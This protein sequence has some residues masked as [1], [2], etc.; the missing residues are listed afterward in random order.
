MIKRLF[1]LPIF[2]GTLLLSLML[3]AV[4]NAQG[5]GIT[6]TG[7]SGYITGEDGSY[8][9]TTSRQTGCVHFSIASDYAFA[10]MQFSFS[11]ATRE[12]LVSG[13]DGPAHFPS[14]GWFWAPATYTS[15]WNWYPGD[16][17][18]CFLPDK[19]STNLDIDIIGSGSANIPDYP[20]NLTRLEI[21]N[22]DMVEYDYVA[23]DFSQTGIW[24][25][26][27]LDSLGR[28]IFYNPITTTEMSFYFAP[29]R[30]TTYSSDLGQADFL[31]NTILHLPANTSIITATG[32]FGPGF[33]EFSLLSG[34]NTFFYD[35]RIYSGIPYQPT[36]GIQ[37]PT[38][39]NADFTTTDAWQFGVTGTPIS[40]TASISNSIL[41]FDGAGINVSQPI[42]A[43]TST[44]YTVV[45]SGTGTSETTAELLIT[46]AGYTDT[47][48]LL[49]TD[50]ITN[51]TTAYL[52]PIATGISLPATTTLQLEML[53]GAAAID[54]V[55]FYSGGVITGTCIPIIPNPQFTTDSDWIY[56]NGGVWNNVAQNAFLP[57][58]EG[59]LNGKTVSLV[60]Q[61]ALSGTVPS[62]ADGQYLILRFD[63]RTL[64]GFGAISSVYQNNDI[65]NTAIMT[66]TAP[67]LDR[68]MRYETPFD[69]FAGDQSDV[70]IAFLNNAIEFK[71]QIDPLSGV[72]VDNLCL[73]A[74]TTEAQLP[75]A[76]T[77]PPIAPTDP[78][79]P[80]NP[81]DPTNPGDPN[82]PPPG[83][84][85][86]LSCSDVTK[87]LSS[88]I[89]VDLLALEGMST[90]AI[91]DFSSWVPWLSGRLWVNVGKPISCSLFITGP[92]RILTNYINWATAT[93]RSFTAAMGRTWETL[94]S[95]LGHLVELL[96]R[97][98]TL[99]AV[100][101]LLAVNYALGRW[102]ALWESISTV[103]SLLLTVLMT[104]WNTYI[105]PFFGDIWS[106][107]LMSMAAIGQVPVIG[108]LLVFLFKAGFVVG[109]SI[110]VFIKGIISIPILFY[111]SF[112]GAIN[113]SA[114]ELIPACTADL[115]NP[116]CRVLWGFEVVNHTIS[117]TFLYP[118]IIIGIIVATIGIFWRQ[119]WNVFSIHFR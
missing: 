17:K 10:S 118:I 51:I 36:T 70:E 3:P 54:Y 18:I 90:P 2:L 46:L 103:V 110:W 6:F 69:F 92:G 4:A 42:T 63:A 107:V 55:C 24:G 11:N 81:I 72:Y 102:Q 27:G 105:S 73:Y 74:S 100:A 104:F 7:I 53:S 49:P 16:Y 21:T 9:L 99:F 91:W 34:V 85:Y 86:P 37:C 87:W 83:V 113:Q 112:N 77:D 84:G 65:V 39:T 64:N 111:Q 93:I 66:Y 94:G 44:S 67:V 97:G 119:I 79:N 80:G 31:N 71:D 1:F 48:I 20:T 78:T 45:V 56:D 14:M 23:D 68:W 15:D 59:T 38:L 5:P 96:K 33:Y 57:V 40:A 47:L 76:P 43:T 8:N 95:W 62:V 117:H 52:S 12:I 89:G 106:F 26:L 13:T 82:D 50:P 98:P 88:L 32:I 109:F 58:V 29:N 75:Y 30:N 35:V 61:L 101:V 22:S 19:G 115:T 41:Y 116:W 25:V 108:G 60:N 114:Y 28:L